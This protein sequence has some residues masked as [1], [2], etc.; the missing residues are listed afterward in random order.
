MASE[1]LEEKQ[2]SDGMSDV[3]VGLTENIGFPLKLLEK[4]NPWPAYVTYTSP[5]VKRLI[6]KSR[7]REL[8]YMKT[9][10]ESWRATRQNKSSSI[11]RLK[12]R[13]S[14]KSFSDLLL[15]DV[16]SDT[17]LSTWD[18]Y[19]VMN[20]SATAVPEPTQLQMETR[21]SPT[22]D[23]NKIIFSRKPVMRRLPYGQQQ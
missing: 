6:E 19:S 4:H 9:V 3:K 15:K 14:T 7:T 2:I 13:K 17:M 11:M 5:I 18:I 20:L 23:Y 22:S 1:T 16:L 21:E 8:E 10:E 12:R